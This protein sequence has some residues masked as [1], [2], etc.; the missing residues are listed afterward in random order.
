M[1]LRNKIAVYTGAALIIGTSIFVGKKVVGQFKAFDPNYWKQ[2]IVE[3]KQKR[4]QI[5]EKISKFDR[6]N[7]YTTEEI[8]MLHDGLMY[9]TTL[10]NYYKPFDKPLPGDPIMG[11]MNVRYRPLFQEYHNI[12][13]ELSGKYLEMHGYEIMH[14]DEISTL[15][16]TQSNLDEKVNSSIDGIK[17]ILTNPKLQ[18]E[19]F[20]NAD[21]RT[22][23]YQYLVGG[24]SALFTSALGLLWLSYLYNKQKES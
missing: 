8:G 9:A 20:K 14:G 6:D 16:L 10:F 21:F 3:E 17:S 4:L 13:T 15:D 12:I 18:E 1:G 11:D 7:K 23:T 19:D 2:K 5:L 22:K 24:F